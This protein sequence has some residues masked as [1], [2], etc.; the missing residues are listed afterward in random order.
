MNIK[1]RMLSM[2]MTHR[3]KTVSIRDDQDR[4]I[5]DNCLN[6]SKF[7]QKMLDIEMNK[8]ISYLRKK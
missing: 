8:S 2:G 4:W 3:I 1:D 6:L 7:L 5:Q